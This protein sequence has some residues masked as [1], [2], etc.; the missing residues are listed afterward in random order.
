MQTGFTELFKVAKQTV[1]ICEVK[2]EEKVIIY[3][4]TG[5]D[6]NLVEAFHTACVNLGCDVT[7]I[8]TVQRFPE[9]NPPAVAIAAM[10]ESD[11]VFDMATQD[12]FYA[13]CT[14]GIL[15]SGT[16]I[17]LFLDVLEENLINRPPDREVCARAEQAAAMMNKGQV[18]RVTTPEG[19][20]FTCRRGDRYANS[21]K[22][23][24]NRPGEIDLYS[25]STIA[26]APLE[27]E[28]EGVLYLNGPQILYPQYTYVVKKPVQLEVE[29]GRIVKIDDSHEDGLIFKRWIEQFEDPNVYTIAHFGFS[30]DHRAHNLS[31]YDLSEWESY[32]GCTMV[33]FGANDNSSLGGKNRAKGHSDSVLLNSTFYI[34]GVPVLVNG[35]FTEESGLR[36][37][38]KG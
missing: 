38:K 37:P 7:L 23:F 14:P 19:T 32:Y 17:L 13:E 5:R 25:N 29:H 24:V 35:E 12:W 1:D 27:T 28:A 3:Y 34:D 18:F 10:K 33:A 16:R 36:P 26:F 15:A 11:I 31:R 2:P 6:T 21:Q 22:G 20:D 30:L 4:D 9:S 8:R